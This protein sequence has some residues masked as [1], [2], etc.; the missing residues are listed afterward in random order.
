MLF[1]SLQHRKMA[2]LLRRN[3]AVLPSEQNN[4]ANDMRRHADLHLALARAQ[5]ADPKLAPA[6]KNSKNSVPQPRPSRP[7]LVWSRN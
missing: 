1:T 4:K 6:A 3:V 7:A 5:E 2:K